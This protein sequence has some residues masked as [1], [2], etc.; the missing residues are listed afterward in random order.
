M[1]ISCEVVKGYGSM[2]EKDDNISL[3]LLAFYTKDT[4]AFYTSW[5]ARPHRDLHV[6][7]KHNSKS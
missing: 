2:N 4:S 5:N 7:A 6:T 1:S 3:G